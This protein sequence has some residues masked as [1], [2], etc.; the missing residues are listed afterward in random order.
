MLKTRIYY[1]IK[2][3]IPRRLQLL[4]RGILVRRKREQCRDI[5]PIDESA[6]KP[7]A[8]WSGLP[9]GKKFALVLT[10][11]VSD[12]LRPT[13][14]YNSLVRRIPLSLNKITGSLLYRHVG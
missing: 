6:G 8:G 5:W 9:D 14:Y 10:H 13:G 3:F 2:P 1:Q 11:F 4:C 12:T 7:P